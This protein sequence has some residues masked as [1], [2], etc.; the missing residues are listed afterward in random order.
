M[1]RHLLE[2]FANYTRSLEI[3]YLLDGIKKAAR[4]DANDIELEKIK[5][6][7]SKKNLHL[8][9][10][11]FKVVKTADKGKG[12]YAN[13]AKK[14]PLNYPGCGL[15]HIYISKDKSRAELL[16]LSEEKNDDRAAGELL[17]YPRCC[18]DFFV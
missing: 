16:K 8:E 14:V 1:I 4:L 2:I 6:F 18:I 12:G 5:D 7:C 17:G 3:L 15:H 13:I 10:S 9:V 11:N